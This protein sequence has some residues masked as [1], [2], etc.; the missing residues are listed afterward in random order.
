MKWFFRNEY[1]TL[2]EN[3]PKSPKE[4]IYLISK[5]DGTVTVV[6]D[7]ICVSFGASQSASPGSN[8]ESFVTFHDFFWSPIPFKQY[9]AHLDVALKSQGDSIV[10]ST[11]YPIKVDQMSIANLWGL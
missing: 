3:F 5:H 2:E 7:C 9:Q 8:R 11:I 1:F 6:G 10:D 4:T